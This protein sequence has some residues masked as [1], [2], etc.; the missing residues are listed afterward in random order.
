M[1][2]SLQIGKDLIVPC[3]DAGDVGPGNQVLFVLVPQQISR[4]FTGIDIYA[5]KPQSVVVVKYQTV[6]LLVSPVKSNV[7]VTLPASQE[8]LGWKP[9][10]RL[11]QQTGQ[12]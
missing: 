2:C 4:R 3:I 7:A 9:L 1:I 5:D 12:Q 11:V 6:G 10:F 8:R